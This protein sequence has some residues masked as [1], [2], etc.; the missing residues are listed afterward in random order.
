MNGAKNII[1]CF[2]I[3]SGTLIG[4]MSGAKL[5][6][7]QKRQLSSKLIEGSY[8][9]VYRAALTVFQDQDYII[10][11]TDMPSGL[12]VAYV[13]REA[14]G[15]T[16]VAGSLLEALLATNS[17][18]MTTASAG[19]ELSCLVNKINETASE[20]RLSIHETAYSNPGES[21]ARAQRTEQ[22]YDEKVFQN[23]FNQISVE[24]KRREAMK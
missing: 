3:L 8:E 12:I 21:G 24:V 9:D 14:I 1:T 15:T 6:P 10:R 2:M 4:C 16:Q 23:F 20:V 18:T 17:G 11:N 5:S 22:I 13:E 19:F 7:M